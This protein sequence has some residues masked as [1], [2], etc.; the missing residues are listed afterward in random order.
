MFREPSGALESFSN[1]SSRCT[2]RLDSAVHPYSSGRAILS[3]PQGGPERNS[4][5]MKTPIYARAAVAGLVAILAGYAPAAETTSGTRVPV[6][7]ELFTS[8]GCSSCPPADRLLE[9]FDR[10]QPFAKADLIVLSEH[11]DY[12]DRLG[13]KD[14]YSSPQF[15]ARQQEYADRFSRDGVYTPQLVVDGRF[16]LVGS[17]QRS[18]SSAIQ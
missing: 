13:W 18:A 8:E 10:T 7:L 5:E 6:L 11:V 3:R 9:T 12:W 2:A 1:I 15:S 16:E 4:S 14:P 17:D